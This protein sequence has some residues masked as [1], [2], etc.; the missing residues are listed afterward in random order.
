MAGTF[1]ATKNNLVT[2]AD[3]LDVSSSQKASF[4]PFSKKI[5][6][7]RKGACN[8]FLKERCR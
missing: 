4:L 5:V 6:L 2:W 1:V 8:V 3:E 7:E